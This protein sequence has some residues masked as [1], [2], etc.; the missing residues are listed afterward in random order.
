MHANR[1]VADIIIVLL[2]ACSWSSIF[3]LPTVEDFNATHSSVTQIVLFALTSGVVAVALWASRADCTKRNLLIFAGFTALDVLMGSFFCKSVNTIFNALNIGFTSCFFLDTI[4]CVVIALLLGTR[5]AVAFAAMYYLLMFIWT[6]GLILFAPV[7]IA[8]AF[9]AG[10]FRHMGGMT[11]W[12]SSAIPG[13]F[14]GFMAA[15]I[16]SPI[17]IRLM[18]PMIAD[19]QNAANLLFNELKF[20]T[21][22]AFY[23]EGYSDPLDKLATFLIGSFIAVSLANHLR[24][25][26]EPAAQQVDPRS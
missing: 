11:N 18:G 24:P 4:G 14:A 20:T 8:V 7:N 13:I 2:V 1:F 23:G 21:V 25:G 19:G 15:L 16:A 22:G 12:F 5:W 10:S 9:C 3:V 6:P 17:N 26:P